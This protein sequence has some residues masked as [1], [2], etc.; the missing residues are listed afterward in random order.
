M[1]IDENLLNKRILWVDWAKFLAIFF[2]LIIHCSSDFLTGGIIGSSNWLITL[3]FESI[4][5]WGIIVFVMVSGFL[6]LRKEYEL[7]EF[8][9]KRFSRVVLPFVFWNIIYI[10]VK[11]V[12]QNPLQGKVTA[13]SVIGF[14][15]NAFLDP[16]IV[17]VQFWFVYMIL[18]L[19]LVT[20][21]LAKWIKN[22]SDLEINYLLIV[23]LIIL[24]INFLNIKFLLCNYLTFFGG[25]L[26]F[27]ILG[28]YLPLKNSK[29]ELKYLNSVKSGLI[30]FIIGFLG[31]F[32][33]TWALSSLSGQLSFTFISL[34]DLTPFAILEA[35]GIYIMIMELVPKITN[36][37]LNYM[38]VK[39]SLASF[40]IYLV[41][42]L[43]I[44][45]LKI[46]GI[47]STSFNAISIILYAILAFIISFIVIMI[48]GKIPIIKKF[49]GL[50]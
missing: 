48:M 11:L 27:F 19:Y 22:V 12:V 16:T 2:I 40:G 49:S 15:I 23:W 7:K 26:G 38:A 43:V 13:F 45:G 34:G 28:Y 25:F 44:N 42:V 30:L 14:F 41:N 29:G 31:I 9:F 39:F 8:L 36:K 1:N 10:V 47:Y 3:F 35:I 46:I 24:L 5:R 21:I 32:L 20:P 50:V 37:K 17:T 4:S 6:L 33:G 18:G